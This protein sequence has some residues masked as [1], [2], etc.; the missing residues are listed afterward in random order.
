VQLNKISGGNNDVKGKLHLVV[1]SKMLKSAASNMVR[2]YAISVLKKLVESNLLKNYSNDK[3]G[4]D[5]AD[6]EEYDN[7]VD[8]SDSIF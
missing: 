6:N 3:D 2:L 5:N 1:G 4:D 8:V 7:E